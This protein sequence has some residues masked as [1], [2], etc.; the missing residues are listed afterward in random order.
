M[1]PAAGW[2]NPAN[3]PPGVTGTQAAEEF[4]HQSGGWQLAHDHFEAMPRDFRLR[5]AQLEFHTAI[6]RDQQ[7]AEGRAA[8]LEQM[9]E[10]VAEL[11]DRHRSALEFY[12][13]PSEDGDGGAADELSYHQIK[14]AQWT[15][16]LDPGADIAAHPHG[17]AVLDHIEAIGDAIT[18]C[19]VTAPLLVSRGAPFVGN[20]EHPVGLQVGVAVREPT[21]V[22]AT[23]GE[24]LHGSFAERLIRMHL[25]VPENVQ[26]A[27]LPA[28]SVSPE[29]LEI[30]FG[31]GTTWIPVRIIPPEHPLNIP[32]DSGER[33]VLPQNQWVVYGRLEDPPPL[34]DDEFEDHDQ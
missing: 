28:I 17:P 10:F 21:F 24:Q 2:L 11:D 4:F 31:S 3:W 19:P 7:A 6:A 32:L 22:S 5:Y 12:T 18:Q 29:E 8:A 16:D 13:N 25:Y 26:G 20:W 34:S 1:P 9:T 23:V 33:T 14:Q 30:L 27:Y 15:L